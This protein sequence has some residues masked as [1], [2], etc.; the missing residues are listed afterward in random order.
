M[1]D[2]LKFANKYL[3]ILD[4]EKV[5]LSN[6][7]DREQYKIVKEGGAVDPA[8]IV[9]EDGVSP[10]WILATSSL[11]G[12]IWTSIVD[13]R[14]KFSL[15]SGFM[16]Q[17]WHTLSQVFKYYEN[18]DVSLGFDYKNKVYTRLLKFNDNE[19]KYNINVLPLDFVLSNFD[20]MT[21]YSKMRFRITYPPVDATAF[22]VTMDTNTLRKICTLVA[23]LNEKEIK[24]YINDGKFKARIGSRTST[25]DN[26]AEIILCDLPGAEDK[27][28]GYIPISIIGMIIRLHGKTSEAYVSGNKLIFNDETDEFSA[29]YQVVLDL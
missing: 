8:F 22:K 9:H 25:T 14:Q 28:I 29:T 18:S 5:A 16:V 20:C 26:N 21:S 7:V 6:C 19:T 24:L 1:L 10:E 2:F 13:K 11:A 12:R 23:S 17:D 3:T 15:E 4:A 27:E